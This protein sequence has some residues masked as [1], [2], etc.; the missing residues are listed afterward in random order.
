MLKKIF[1]TFRDVSRESR[2]ISL[3]HVA[4]RVIT[5]YICAFFMSIKTRVVSVNRVADRKGIGKIMIPRVSDVF[6]GFLR[7]SMNY[8]DSIRDSGLAGNAVVSFLS[9]AV[10]S[11]PYLSLSLSI[12]RL[13]CGSP[14]PA[15]I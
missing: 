1:Q 12:L 10:V 2:K 3:S 7:G 13:S 14:T 15:G 4:R 9:L 6:R 5:S 11:G 8:T